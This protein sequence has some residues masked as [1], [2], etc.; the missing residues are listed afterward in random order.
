MASQLEIANWALM[1]IGEKR[2]SSL[3][4]DNA[5]A[6]NISAA[7]DFLRD[8]ALRRQAWHFAIE[9]TSLAADAT[10]PDWGFDYRYA[11]AGDVVKVLQVSEY[12]P[13][14]DLGDYRNSDT[15]Q[16]R[17]EG[18]YILT[19][20][21]APLYVKW[22]VNS[23][24][25]GEWDPSFAALMAADIAEYLAPRTVQSDATS[26]R[27]AAWRAEAMAEANATNAVEDPPE[28]V[29][30]DSWMAAHAQ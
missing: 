18:R 12:Y 13:G 28:P 25:V 30:D 26:Q 1:L 20:I 17:I 11:L 4:D 23:V 14:V 16:H 19:D 6:E 22:V 21:G 3:S 27:I 5:N 10:A 8:R 2:L 29:A 24:D 15:A 7:W 9:R